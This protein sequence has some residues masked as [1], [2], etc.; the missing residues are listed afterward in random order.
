V[1]SAGGSRVAEAVCPAQPRAVRNSQRSINGWKVA[2]GERVRAA[3][4]RPRLA[5]KARPHSGKIP[6]REW[7][8]S[9]SRR[10]TVRVMR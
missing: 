2:A 6:R 4:T 9:S 7:K 3:V 8:V 5:R 1:A 10:G